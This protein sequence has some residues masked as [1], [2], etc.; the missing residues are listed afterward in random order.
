M[1]IYDKQAEQ[2]FYLLDGWDD[3]S[4]SLNAPSWW[5]Q[6]D[7]VFQTGKQA[8][9]CCRTEVPRI[10]VVHNEFIW[11]CCDD[12]PV[13]VEE[14]DPNDEKNL[15]KATYSKEAALADW[16]ACAAFAAEKINMKEAA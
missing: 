15:L 14:N 1:E 5:A 3:W 6:Q 8:C 16:I 2:E 7:H 13:F 9:P 12:L 11:N 10:S 4:D